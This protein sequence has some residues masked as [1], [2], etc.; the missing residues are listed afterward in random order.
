LEKISQTIIDIDKVTSN[1]LKP[2]C[3]QFPCSFSNL[4]IGNTIKR[5]KSNTSTL[6]KSKTKQPLPLAST[7]ENIQQKREK[8]IQQ[9]ETDEKYYSSNQFIRITF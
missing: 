8:K 6:Q 4:N 2:H 9:A 5:N 7:K 3:N 1:N